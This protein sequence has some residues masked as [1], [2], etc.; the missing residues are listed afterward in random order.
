MKLTIV[1]YHKVNDTTTMLDSLINQMTDD[2][3]IVVIDDGANCKALDKYKSD[4]IIVKH[5]RKTIGKRAS[6]EIAM[7]KIKNGF[8]AIF[9]AVDEVVPN[10]IEKIEKAITDD[11][12]GITYGYGYSNWNKYQFKG[13]DVAFAR[14]YNSIYDLELFKSINKNCENTVTIDDVL[15]QHKRG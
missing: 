15:Y 2:I 6:V 3:G 4:S 7:R 11:T 10:F 14:E 5:N 13:S 8:V 1:I 12:D 9:N